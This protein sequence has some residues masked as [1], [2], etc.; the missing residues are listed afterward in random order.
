MVTDH[1]SIGLQPC[2]HKP[3][4]FLTSG[5]A[6]LGGILMMRGGGGGGGGGR[7]VVDVT[8]LN[9]PGAELLPEPG[10]SLM[11]GAAA[12]GGSLMMRGGGGGG[13]GRFVDDMVNLNKPKNQ[14]QQISKSKKPIGDRNKRHHGEHKRTDNEAVAVIQ[15]E[16]FIVI[17]ECVET[18]VIDK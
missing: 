8:T 11:S 3:C 16:A 18:G 17:G 2:Y 1:V 14:R 9:S 15:P 7:V 6:G 10:S 4:Y 13:G 5:T 12:L